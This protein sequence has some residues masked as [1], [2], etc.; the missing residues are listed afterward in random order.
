LI[1]QLSHFVLGLGLSGLGLFGWIN[2]SVVALAQ[3]S[4]AQP[5]AESPSPNPSPQS[6]SP[7]APPPPPSTP[8]PN[9]TRSG[10]SLGASS[11]CTN[12]VQTSTQTPTQVL[13]A[14]VPIDN[15]VLTTSEYPTFLFYV[16]YSSKQVKF[17]E[18]S[19]LVGSAETTRLYRSRFTLPETPGIV[20]ISL[21]PASEAA[22]GKDIYYHWYFKLYCQENT[23]VRA[24]LEVNGWIK[25]ID[26]PSFPEINEQTMPIAWYDAVSN[27]ADRLRAAPQDTTLKNRWRALL[28]T[29]HAEA[30]A[31]EPLVGSVHLL[32]N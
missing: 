15:P 1:S 8:P 18:F 13:T 29:I 5:L 25:R 14:L 9:S 4:P 17:G 6:P 24:D 11:S 31:N 30:L 2:A 21:P 32:E 22:I 7:H 3:R 23:S 19:I 28:A 27:L 10:G 20:S 12:P 16:P 26:L